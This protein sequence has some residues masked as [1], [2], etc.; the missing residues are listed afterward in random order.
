MARREAGVYY[1]PFIENLR[2]IGRG[3]CRNKKEKKKK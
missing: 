3:S 1:F 2:Q